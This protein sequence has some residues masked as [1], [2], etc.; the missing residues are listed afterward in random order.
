M[1]SKVFAPRQILNREA[2]QRPS[3]C[4]DDLESFFYIFCFLTNAYDAY[5]TDLKVIPPQMDK[6]FR[7][8]FAWPKFMNHW[9]D[10]DGGFEQ[11]SSRIF[12]S[13]CSFTAHETYSSSIQTLLEDWRKIFLRTERIR[14]LEYDPYYVPDPKVCYKK[15]LGS[16]RK[17]LKVLRSSDH[18]RAG[19]KRATTETNGS[20]KR[21]NRRTVQ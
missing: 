16:I 11:K 18:I 8:A 14:I 3:H 17:A 4:M 21:R 19:Q 9:F 6:P 13:R 20:R 15:V 10:D 7:S 12:E 2:E 1:V 5:G